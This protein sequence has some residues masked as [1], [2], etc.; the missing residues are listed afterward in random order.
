MI[1]IPCDVF[2]LFESVLVVD[3]CTV[4]MC[5]CR[6]C[7]CVEDVLLGMSMVWALDIGA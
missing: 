3:I 7:L 1:T 5:V 2:N 4:S 6:D